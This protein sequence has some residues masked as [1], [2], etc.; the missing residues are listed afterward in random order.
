MYAVD[1]RYDECCEEFSLMHHCS[2]HKIQHLIYSQMHEETVT[3]NEDSIEDIVSSFEID[4][5]IL[6]PSYFHDNSVVLNIA[7]E[8][9]T[10]ENYKQIQDDLVALDCFKAYDVYELFQGGKVEYNLTNEADFTY[11]QHYLLNQ[12]EFFHIIY[13]PVVVWM[14]SFLQGV[15]NIVAFGIQLNCN[16]K[17]KLPI[18]FLLQILHAFFVSSFSYKQEYHFVEQM[19]TWLHWKFGYT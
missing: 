7:K 2:K 5:G 8:F 9:S 17:Y 1:S 19:L 16:S 3:Q 13:D 10:Q 18:I 4:E 12:A 6:F 14:D 11:E 15:P